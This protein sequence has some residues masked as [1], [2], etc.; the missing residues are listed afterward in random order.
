MVIGKLRSDDIYNQLS[1]YPRPEHSSNALAN[2]A[3]ML[4]VCLYFAPKFLDKEYACMRG[5][6][7]K[8]FPDNWIVP[9]YMGITVNL[10]DSWVSHPAA[11]EAL[12]N[13]TKPNSIKEIANKHYEKL[14]NCLQSKNDAMLEENITKILFIL[15]EWNVSFRWIMLHSFPSNIQF[16]NTDYHS[17]L[18][19][20]INGTNFKINEIVEM[21]LAI[22][23]L[24]NKVRENV[25]NLLGSKEQK[26]NSFKNDTMERIVELSEVFSGQ[27]ALHKVKK[28]DS[29]KNWFADIGKEIDQLCLDN[30]HVSERK[31]IQLRKVL[32]EVEEFH[33]LDSNMQIKQHLMEC[34]QYLEEMITIVKINEETLINIQ[35]ISDFS[36]AFINITNYIDIMQN[37]LINS[38]NNCLFP[39]REVI[40]KLASALEVPL[41]RINQAQSDD[42]E[43][44]SSYYSNELIKFM[45]TFVQI[46]PQYIFDS[47][48]DYFKESNEL[49]RTLKVR[50]EIARLTLK[51][52]SLTDNILSMN[53]TLV[54]TVE[55]NPK[56]LLEDSIRKELGMHLEIVFNG[57]IT[58]KSGHMKERELNAALDG[59]G[60]SINKYRWS[61]EYIQDYL[62][63]NGLKIFDEEVRLAINSVI[64][65]FFPENLKSLHCVF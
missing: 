62:H 54:G 26:W 16:S 24:E 35:L 65:I 21:L 8:F 59:I 47:I 52:S 55:M 38:P 44:V 19:K 14:Q 18:Y 30:R 34:R 23:Q 25:T 9:I 3:A 22:S 51:I 13:T 42:L 32:E 6:V 20:Q 48:I 57:S 39:F 56:S 17:E 1:I 58:H 7:D 28:N 15:R 10:M 43:S 4:Y 53:T 33:N 46:I 40:L 11:L 27:K 45:R 63:T 37:W 60:K 61:L 12:K 29:L 41:L 64:I 2:Q 31:M 50:K 36:Y 49:P 5:I